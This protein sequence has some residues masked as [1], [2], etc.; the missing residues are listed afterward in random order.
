MY[1]FVSFCITYISM[2]LELITP[3]RSLPLKVSF[4]S[5]HS[6]QVYFP[7]FKFFTRLRIVYTLFFS[8]ITF[9]TKCKRNKTT[10]KRTST[11]A[12]GVHP[13]RANQATRMVI[14]QWGGNCR[15]H[16]TLLHGLGL[17]RSVSF[18]TSISGGSLTL[19]KDAES[20]A[21]TNVE[22]KEV[23]SIKVD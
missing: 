12:L 2:T 1:S 22:Q 11:E 7:R 13:E 20:S 17:V 5:K 4:W 19:M 6:G 21:Q 9:R 18:C 8:S 15:L 16:T 3:Q 10:C 23:A 14:I